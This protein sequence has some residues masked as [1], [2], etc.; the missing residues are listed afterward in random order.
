MKA[1][2]YMGSGVFATQE[3]ALP[4]PGPQEALI[5]VSFA[6]ICGT[7]MAIVSDKHPRAKPP[8]VPGH[9]ISGRVES[10]GTA[11][12]RFHPGDRVVV[13]PLITCGHCLP[14]RTGNEHVCN[15]L[16]LIGIDCDGG[17]QEYVAIPERN[18]LL[19]PGELAD[20]EAAMVETLAVIVHGVRESGFRFGDTV[21]VTG[22]GPIGLLN[23]AVLQEMGASRIFVTEIDDFRLARC[24]AYGFAAIDL[25]T[26]DPV[27]LIRSQ[28]DGEGA[29]LLFECSG[30]AV[31]VRN[32]MEYVRC[33]ATVVM[34]SVPK[35]PLPVNLRALNFKEIHLIGSRVYS[36]VDFEIAA[37]YAVRL[38]AQ[39]GELISHRIPVG[40]GARAFAV[41]HDPEE[42]PLKVLISCHDGNE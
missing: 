40:Q 1:L 35:Q 31:A 41:A 30:N 3:R 28:T 32:M 10:V 37:R 16:K 33:K 34:M 12:V 29:D 4:V 13:N 11:C 20:D 18:L 39:L 7:D 6:G 9:E 42:H 19:M 25:K 2:T 36:T 38:K 22:A 5:R 21:V 27:E 15:T 14:C 17:M 26:H 24:K 23:A 8:L